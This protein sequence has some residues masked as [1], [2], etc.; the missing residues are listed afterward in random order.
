MA[1][2]AEAGPYVGPRPFE[3]RDESLF[4]GREPESRELLS[5]V[6]AHQLVV[7]YAQSGAGKTSLLNARLAPR[8]E[9]RGLEVLSGRVGGET[10]VDIDAAAVP[11]P[12]SYGV[13]LSLVPQGSDPREMLQ[14]SLAGFFRG[15]EH[16]TDGDGQ[17]LPRVLVLSLIHI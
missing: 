14:E 6:I 3:R 4:F 1:E 10:P 7:F 13:L 17:P 9:D 12:F 5:R 8:L 2:S 16:T 15:R 11:N